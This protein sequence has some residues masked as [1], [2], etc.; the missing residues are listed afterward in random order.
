MKTSIKVSVFIIV[1]S[2]FGTELI[3]ADSDEPPQQN[4]S[5]IILK[6]VL[7]QF[8]ERPLEMEGSLLIKN[9]KG[10]IAQTYR[11]NAIVNI[12]TSTPTAKYSFF[13]PESKSFLSLETVVH[14][15]G[16]S[17]SV[18]KKGLPPKIFE[19]PPLDSPILGSDIT[20]ENLS[21]QFLKWTN[22]VYVGSDTVLGLNCSMIKLYPTTYKDT[23]HY[24]IWVAQKNHALMRFEEYNA[25]NKLK[26]TIWI[27]S[28]KKIDDGFTVK[29]LEAESFPAVHRTKIKINSIYEVA[30]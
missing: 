28:L 8:P 1:A 29:D 10:F 22:T 24:K 14:P 18:F 16:S 23:D 30:E 26:R 2:V 4:E 5:D 17:K 11:F 25:E 19:A 12:N 9:K 20:W 13:I 15:D 6:Q 7:A 27:K 3:S 21:L